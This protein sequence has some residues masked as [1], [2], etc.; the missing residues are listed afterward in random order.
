[1][2]GTVINNLLKAAMDNFNW[3]IIPSTPSYVALTF[4]IDP[5]T[6]RRELVLQQM[7]VE[8]LDNLRIVE[9]PLNVPLT[10]K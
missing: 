10:A 1:M 8:H 7:C 5:H 9:L 3:E 4:R 2:R 6:L